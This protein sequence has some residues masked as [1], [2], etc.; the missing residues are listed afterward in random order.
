MATAPN[1]ATVNN[2]RRVKVLTFA[3]TEA[4]ADRYLWLSNA[5]L[6]AGAVLILIGTIGAIAMSSAKE[7]FANERISA[8]EADTARA[9]EAAARANEGAVKAQLALEKYKATR[10]SGLKEGDLNLAVAEL[11][12]FSGTKFDAGIPVGNDECRQLL[13][14]LEDVLRAAGFSQIDWKD[15]KAGAIGLERKG[16]PRVGAVTARGVMVEVDAKKHPD[17]WKVAQAMEKAF[18]DAGV[19]MHAFPEIATGAVNDCLH[20]LVG[21]KTA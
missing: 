15:A 20:L 11:K 8:N 14:V 1:N 4:L 12:A 17:L 3:V 9:N 13:T 10:A 18:K 6:I 2:P 21:E 5:A 16:R 7:H 19:E